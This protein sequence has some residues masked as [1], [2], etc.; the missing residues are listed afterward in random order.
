MSTSCKL[1]FGYKDHCDDFIITDV[2]YRHY[3]G[4]ME[5]VLPLLKEHKAD[6]TT[7][8]MVAEFNGHKWEKLDSVYDGVSGVDYIYYIDSSDKSEIKCSVIGIDMDF[9]L[10]YG[11]DNYKVMKN[12]I[13]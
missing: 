6:I 1:V 11:V 12:L 2:Y 7:M 13:L 4:Y 10:K 9:V 3:D 5:A 8:N